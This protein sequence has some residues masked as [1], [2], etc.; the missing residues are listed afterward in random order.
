[1]I[2]AFKILSEQG[3]AAGVRRIEAL[4]GEN[5][6]KYIEEKNE[7]I[8]KTAQNLKCGANDIDSKA[9]IVTNEVKALQ[10]QISDIQANAALSQLESLINSGKD[11]G[12]Y[13]FVCGTLN[14]KAD[15]LREMCDRVKDKNANG[16]ALL[17]AVD[18]E[19]GKVGIAAACGKDAV[20]NGANAGAIV[21]KA[22]TLCGGGGGGRPDSA[23]AGGKDA[24]TI[25]EA[26][27]AV[28][29]MLK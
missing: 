15:V 22:A 5:V 26:I 11:L 19:T 2:G 13:T 21:K 12:K 25:A 1:M 27:A 24:S 23:T 20:K 16:V 14:A 28:E 8:A 9:E 3:V 6:L 4:T 18:A 7:L 29:E 10:K 17:F